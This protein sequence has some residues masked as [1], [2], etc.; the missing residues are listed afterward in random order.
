METTQILRIAEEDILRILAE[1][2][3]G[4]LDSIK[5]KVK[6]SS[7][8]MSKAL[9]E[10]EGEKLIETEGNFIKLT[11]IG[12]KKSKNILRKHLVFE[13]YLKKSLNERA[14]HRKAH[15][16]EH[17]VSKEVTKNIEK[18]YTLEERGIPLT[19]FRLYKEGLITDVDIP[20][21]G[22]FERIVSMGIVPGERT[23]I[24]SVIPGCVVVK[25]K[26]KKFALD[27]NI[28]KKIG[29]L[30]YEKS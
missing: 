22:L 20:N 18:L 13:N 14:A 26:N 23:K 16:L 8:F 2:K 4:A 1:E 21:N 5:T 10:L 6:V 11:K 15:I 24:A 3:K 19:K 7:F 25:I 28:A 17:Y 27:D 29:V 30:K 12:Q 9:K